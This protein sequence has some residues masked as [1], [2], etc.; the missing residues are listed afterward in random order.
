M[1]T[2]P[3]IA[4]DVEGRHISVGDYVVMKCRDPRDAYALVLP[5][6]SDMDGDPV[7]VLICKVKSVRVQELLAGGGG[8]Q[9]V[10]L[11]GKFFKNSTKDISD[12]LVLTRKVQSVICDTWDMLNVYDG[13]EDLVLTPQDIENLTEIMKQI[14]AHDAELVEAASDD[15]EGEITTSIE[16][17]IEVYEDDFDDE[18]EDV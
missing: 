12:P 4:G 7:Y 1:A 9:R 2:L 15:G 14:L 17:E 3:P 6:V 16:G 5:D 18:I 10:H 13:A 11:R 8:D